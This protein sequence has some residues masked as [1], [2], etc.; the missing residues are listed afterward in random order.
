MMRFG[1]MQY[2]NNGGHFA[3]C[4][5]RTAPVAD[6]I[7]AKLARLAR[8]LTDA[9]AQ[10]GQRDV[11]RKVARVLARSSGRITDGTEREIMRKAPAS[12]WSPPQ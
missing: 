10:Q 12:G 5:D 7:G 9:I 8:R 2:T 11:D 6:G 1:S 3:A 4:S